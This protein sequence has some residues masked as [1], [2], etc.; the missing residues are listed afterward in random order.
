[1]DREVGEAKSEISL[2]SPDLEKVN[3]SEDSVVCLEF[4]E[5]LPA[6]C[7]P[8]SACAPETRSVWRIVPS[9]TP[10]EN[11]FRSHA[12]LKKPLPERICACVASSCSVFS[13]SKR[14]PKIFG[15]PKFKKKFVATFEIDKDSGLIDENFTTGHIDFWMYKGFD[16]TLKIKSVIANKDLP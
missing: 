10:T 15:L 14:K 7:P 6:G 1:M 4:A 2:T 13:P 11:D 9:E 8:Q 16:P 5:Q 12:F 3:S